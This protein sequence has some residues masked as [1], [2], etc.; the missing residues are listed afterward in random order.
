MLNK[1]F[2]A[3]PNV[4]DN[5][6][7]F[8]GF[9]LKVI[10]FLGLLLFLIVWAFYGKRI[11]NS[12]YNRSLAQTGNA[13]N[14]GAEFVLSTA[15]G[16]RNADIIVSRV[17]ANSPAERAGLK[18]RDRV[19]GVNGVFISSPEMAVRILSAGPAGSSIKLTVN[20]NGRNQDIY[21]PADN[22]LPATRGLKIKSF[23][24][25]KQ[26]VTIVLFLKMVVLMF[27]FIYKNIAAR[28]YIALFFAFLCVLTGLFGGIYGPVDAFFA[29][30][31]NTISLLLG[32]GIISVVLD[33]AGF[34]DCIA[35]RIYKFA[36]ESRL[37]ILILF[38][39]ITYGFSL[40]VNN[41]TTIFI[42]VPMTLKLAALVGFDP[43]PVVIGEV[44]SSNLGGASTM[45]G[46]FPNMLISAEA[47][48]GFNQF[49][50][51]MMPI[52]LILMAILL[53]FLRLKTSNFA[54]CRKDLSSTAEIVE[55]RL[56]KREQ[57]AVRRAVFILFHVIFLFIISKRISL[58]P[59]AIALFGGLSLFLL[60]GI[61]RRRLMS[62]LGFNDVLFFAGLFI[63]VGGL[64]ASGILRYISDGIA[65]LSSGRPLPLCLV[66]M[67]TAAFLTAFLSAGPSTALF[68]PIVFG[69]GLSLPHHIIWWA[70][71]LGVLAGSSATI[72]GATAGP[73]AATLVENFSSRHSVDLKDGNTISYAEFAKIGIPVMFLFLLVSSIYISWLCMVFL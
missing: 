46:D 17:Y 34:F 21:V 4:V 15:T 2:T 39:L 51:F 31:F 57:S 61:N 43:R 6:V 64:E 72:V 22:R 38:C 28:T 65:T 24:W 30:K 45:I 35:Y 26:V 44:I 40:L 27:Y 55:P 59:S 10:L 53:V 49:I 23:T 58:N 48:I 69:I 63:V 9:D 50:V 12:V 14:S 56:T 33:E 25:F 11:E 18:K 47:G 67:W 71:S 68:F 54:D 32:M 73:V 20:R 66:L 7:G 16:G 62:R 42:I 41:L 52:C 29:I 60:S 70:L 8:E 37:K 36:G 5:T 1:T 13:G 3:R 19:I